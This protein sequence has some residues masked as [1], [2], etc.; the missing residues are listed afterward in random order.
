MKTQTGRG[1]TSLFGGESVTAPVE[2][3]GLVE[4]SYSQWIQLAATAVCVGIGLLWLLG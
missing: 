2:Y 1:M 3:E 4:R